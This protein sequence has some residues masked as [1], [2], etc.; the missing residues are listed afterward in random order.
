MAA[1]LRR[2]A[3]AILFTSSPYPEDGPQLNARSKSAPFSSN[4]EGGAGLSDAR[5]LQL[6]TIFVDMRIKDFLAHTHTVQTFQSTE[7][8]WNTDSYYYFRLPTEAVV[9]SFK[10]EIGDNHA[11]EDRTRSSKQARTLYNKAVH[12]KKPAAILREVESGVYQANL[13]RIPPD[14]QVTIVVKHAERVASNARGEVII[15][16]PAVFSRSSSSAHTRVAFEIEI[17]Q[18]DLIH[19]ISS[20]THQ[21]LLSIKAGVTWTARELGTF[22]AFQQEDRVSN[23]EKPNQATVNFSGSYAVLDKDFEL[24]IGASNV[25]K[26][27]AASL[28]GPNRFGHAVLT[29]NIRPCDLFDGE[30]DSEWSIDLELN[31]PWK[32]C[33]AD[34]SELNLT[35]IPHH[36]TSLSPSTF[37][38]VQSPKI[39]PKISHL[40]DYSVFFLLDLKGSTEYSLDS[41]HV[42]ARP[43][44]G[45]HLV[46]TWTLD[47]G[48]APTADGIWQKLCVSSILRDL[49]FAMMSQ[50]HRQLYS[51][52]R[53]FGLSSLVTSAERLGQMYSICN[54]WTSKIAADSI[55][56]SDEE[57]D[58]SGSRL[59]EDELSRLTLPTQPYHSD[60]PALNWAPQAGRTQYGGLIADQVYSGAGFS[61][62]NPNMEVG[63]IRPDIGETSGLPMDQ[64][65]ARESK[66]TAAQLNRQNEYFIPR[67][68]IDREVITADINR[69]LGNDALVRPGTYEDKGNGRTV[70]GYF[71]TAYRNLTSAMIA[72][73]KAD[74]ARWQ[75]ER[76]TYSSGSAQHEVRTGQNYAAYRQKAAKDDP[77]ACST[78]GHPGYAAHTQ[79]QAYYVQEPYF[80]S[81]ANLG[82][83]QQAPRER[84][85]QEA[86]QLWPQIAASRSGNGSYTLPDD[87]RA[88]IASHFTHGT[89]EWL[90]ARV[91]K[92]FP[93]KNGELASEAVVDLILILAFLKIRIPER[94]EEVEQEAGLI[95]KSGW[96]QRAIFE[97]L[98]LRAPACRRD[99]DDDRDRDRRRR[100]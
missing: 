30:K 67:I 90:V 20:P 72:D 23:L 98:V 96:D 6:S 26:R 55:C 41:V 45:N 28:S 3:S 53:P 77:S 29:V 62:S 56:D 92:V 64:R 15:K 50:E 99:P 80:S 32:S 68:G 24:V 78:E 36:G 18:Q 87:L 40:Q 66:A 82:Y 61:L 85:S 58:S 19:T 100:R 75:Q 10:I 25:A 22:A 49:Y 69:Y 57:A 11:I 44:K 33:S 34:L 95:L 51:E 91:A 93:D 74:S 76:R 7:K 81:G 31:H 35:R 2:L 16:Y 21:K 1:T 63:P 27:T 37:N 71:I 83:A 9:T 46:K 5:C 89:L 94:Y 4:A 47:V 86:Q 39:L 8:S 52:G 48:R 65:R 79:P 73:L 17:T 70:Q 14:V 60:K 54:H 97:E 88:R 42:T 59:C 12:D 13:G 43:T 84:E 38:F